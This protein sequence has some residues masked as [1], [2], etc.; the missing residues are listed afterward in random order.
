MP[1][2]CCSVCSVAVLQTRKA[3]LPLS[4]SC[5]GLPV[6][7]RRFVVAIV[8]FVWFAL[9]CV[10][11]IVCVASRSKEAKP[12]PQTLFGPRAKSRRSG[13]QARRQPLLSIFPSAIPFL[14]ESH[15]VPCHSISCPVSSIRGDEM[16]RVRTPSHPVAAC[17]GLHYYFHFYFRWF[18]FVVVAAQHAFHL[19]FELL[20]Q[21]CVCLSLQ[22]IED[23]RERNATHS[24]GS[25]TR[26][27]SG[28][29]RHTQVGYP[30][31]ETKSIHP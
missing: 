27:D 28:M 13:R 15:S 5:G 7:I 11:S 18:R 30:L 17:Q 4:T 14:L 26:A 6:S 8:E 22:F 21:S 25:G 10:R 24:G 2:V 23:I 12:V 19:P 16:S 3:S 29:H 9:L 31:S 20:V 1:N